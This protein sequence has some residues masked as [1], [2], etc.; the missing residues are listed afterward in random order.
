MCNEGAHNCRH[1]GRGDKVTVNSEK[2][3]ARNSSSHHPMAVGE[4]EGRCSA[5]ALTR[6]LKSL[7]HADLGVSCFMYIRSFLIR[8]TQICSSCSYQSQKN[9]IFTSYQQC[10]VGSNSPDQLLSIPL[11][12]WSRSLSSIQLN[13]PASSVDGVTGV[14]VSTLESGLVSW[15]KLRCVYQVA[16]I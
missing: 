8:K 12:Y 2:K 14:P 10:P 5:L 3:Q 13:T 9:Q 16:A 15:M 11:E 7:K 4:G 1:E 6:A